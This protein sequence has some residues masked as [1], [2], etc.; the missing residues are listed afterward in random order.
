MKHIRYRGE[1]RAISGELYRIEILQEADQPFEISGLHFPLQPADIEWAELRKYE[2]LH[3]SS[4]TITL[5]SDTDRRFI[6]LYTVREGDVQCDIYRDNQLY[7]SGNIDPETYEEPHAYLDNYDVSL[8][9]NDFGCLDRYKWNRTGF[10]TIRDIIH[11]IIGRTG[12]RYR[13]ITELCST[14]LDPALSTTVLTDCSVNQDNFYDEKGTPMS[15]KEVLESVLQAFALK[16]LQ[17][18]GNIY[19]YDLNALSGKTSKEVVWS[20]IDAMAS[21]DVTYN[22]VK[23]SFSPYEKIELLKE[24]VDTK[25]LTAIKQLDMYVPEEDTLPGFAMPIFL[26]LGSKVSNLPDSCGFEIKPINSGEES[27]GIAVVADKFN[28]STNQWDK[29]ITADI[30]TIPQNRR[31]FSMTNIPYLTSNADVAARRKIRIELP[32]LISPLRNPFE[33]S[34]RRN[35]EGNWGEFKSRCIYGFIPF[36]LVLKDESGR[37]LCHYNNR[38]IK[39][40]N[41]L[42]TGDGK[43]VEGDCGYDQAYFA[44]YSTDRS[45]T[46]FNGWSHNKPLFGRFFGKL[47]EKF[48]QREGQYIPLPQV[49]SRYYSGWLELSVGAGVEL[50]NKDRSA[51]YYKE[52][53][54]KDVH[55]LL[56]KLPS[57]VL[58]DQYYKTIG[59]EDITYDAWINRDAKEEL[60]LDTVIGCNTVES[61]CSLGQIV[62]TVDKSAVKTFYRG[63]FSGTIEKLLIGT[64]YSNYASRNTVLSGTMEINPEFGTFTDKFAPG[65]YIITTQLQHL[66]GS[67]EET[68]MITFKEDHYESSQV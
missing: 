47:P 24:E 6:D 54:Y 25:N 16:L 61:P 21:V 60:E 17:K 51:Q 66:A 58:V 56:Y 43:W 32:V 11:Y 65:K 4:A 44:Y 49:N 12:I 20:D 46:P 39:D 30:M 41:G 15:L 13:E 68:T 22:N 29:Y 26:S 9:F 40:W 7:W 37:V 1:F 3:N 36:R 62:K 57:I 45:A 50:L 55:W 18:N 64:I 31:L 14:K 52:K 42:N 38:G 27:Q 8:T 19:I 34:S 28:L 23:I 2:P 5:I 35:E 67:E 53:R 48:S 63:I 59:S 10:A 33:P